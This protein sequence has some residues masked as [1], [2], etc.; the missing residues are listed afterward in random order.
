[1]C[2]VGYFLTAAAQH[3]ERE[4][5]AERRLK[6]ARSAKHAPTEV[7]VLFETL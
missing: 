6:A 4:V 5:K 3:R 7:K 2:Q 1:M